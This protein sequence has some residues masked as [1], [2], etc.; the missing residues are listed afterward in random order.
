M[1]NFM[2]DNFL[3]TNDTAVKLYHE[4]A[5]EMPIIDYH[6]HLSPK[7]I[8]ENKKYKNI[9]EIWLGGDH[10]KWRAM[11]INGI[12]EDYITGDKPDK[13]KFYKWAE[14]MENSIGNPLYAW[15]HLELKRYFGIEDVLSTKTAEKIWN[16]A[17]ELLQRDEFSCKELIKKSNV[18]IICTTD[19]PVDTLEYHKEI[20]EDKEFNVK[21]LPTF[22]PDK[23]INI[24]KDGFFE[25]LQKLE[26]AANMKIADIDSLLKA[27]GKRIEFF[28]ETGC[29]L[30]DHGLDPIA[31]EHGESN[32]VD[33]IFKKILKK[34]IL[35]EREI[36]VYKGQIMLFLGKE[37]AK[38][39]WTMQIHLG[40]MRNNNKK[41]F[42]LLGPDAGFDSVGDY[43]YVQDLSNFLDTLDSTN[44]LPK[45]IL[46]CLN[47]KDNYVLGSLIGCFQG[48]G[49]PGKIQFGSAWWFNDQKEG[50]IRQMTD[51]ANL[52]L[53]PRFVGM[54]TDSR[55]FL[56][57]T[58]HEYFRR[59]LCNLISEWVENNEVPYDMELLGNIV[60]NISYNNAK[61]YFGI[62]V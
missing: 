27:L 31:F 37:Y 21:I 25:W 53:L 44:E 7:E 22:R 47:P 60:K 28:H 14:T 38:R 5:K 43:N 20:L 11:R 13:E 33:S 32:E 26:N 62:E 39:E 48:D 42:K 15:A 51:L 18:K 1:K 40:C 16:K 19:D 6:C 17:N 10:Y 49:I 35:S 3:L 58:R 12:T 24:E 29:R 54:L 46:Y 34:E 30:S 57:Y 2:N 41:M 52:G 45:T 59:I 55:S 61:N 4:Y 50:M 56:S 8:S 23:A 36:K 9:T